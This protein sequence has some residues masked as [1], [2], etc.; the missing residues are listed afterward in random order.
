MQ[1]VKHSVCGKNNSWSR[2]LYYYEIRIVMLPLPELSI[3]RTEY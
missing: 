1:I 3:Q 2:N